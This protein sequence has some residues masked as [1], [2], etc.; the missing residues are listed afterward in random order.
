MGAYTNYPSIGNSYRN[1]G[2]YVGLQ[3]K[4]SDLFKYI[5]FFIYLAFFVKIEKD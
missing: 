1:L 2:T 4:F 5:S 3:H